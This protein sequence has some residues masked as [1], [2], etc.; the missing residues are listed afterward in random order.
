MIK[1]HSI[2]VTE[3]K[4][5]LSLI[6]ACLF[7]CITL[8][9][10]CSKEKTEKMSGKQT[11]YRAIG[12]CEIYDQ[13]PDGIEKSLD[14]NY[15]GKIKLIGLTVNKMPKNQL[16]IYYFWQV[17]D[18]FVPYNV[19]FVH[20]VGPDNKILFGNDHE[21]CQKRPFS[22]LNNKFIKETLTANLPQS[23]IGKEVDIKIGLYAPDLASSPRLKIKSAGGIPVD[24][25]NTRAIVEKITL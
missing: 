9:L 23:I 8:L 15:E 20:F 24:D 11:A 21:F 12:G 16:K 14:V 1:A 3:A 22:E 7:V 6:F 10:G 25:N 13:K 5:T 4:K 18:E 2:D 19:V 17:M